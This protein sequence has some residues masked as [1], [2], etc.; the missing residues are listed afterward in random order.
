MQQGEDTVTKYVL[1]PVP[2]AANKAFDH[3]HKVICDTADI[4]SRLTEIYSERIKADS[5]SQLIEVPCVAYY[6]CLLSRPSSTGIELEERYCEIAAN[7]LRQEV[8]F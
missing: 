7:R 4:L 2:P 5:D 8:L 1:K 3:T 6:G